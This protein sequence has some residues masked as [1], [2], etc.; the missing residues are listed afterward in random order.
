M[1]QW[2]KSYVLLISYNNQVQRF[3]EGHTIFDTYNTFLDLE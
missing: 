2:Y 3:W 1:K